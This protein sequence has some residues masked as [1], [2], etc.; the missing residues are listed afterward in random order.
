MGDGEATLPI[1]PGGIRSVAV[2]F[3][4]RVFILRAA[5]CRRLYGS[6]NVFP[7]EEEQQVHHGLWIR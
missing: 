7:S 2:S 5:I 1:L 6:Q 3:E 4:R